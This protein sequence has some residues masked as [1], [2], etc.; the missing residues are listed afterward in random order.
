MKLRSSAFFA[1]VP[2]ALTPFVVAH[3]GSGAAP[4]SPDGGVTG[5]PTGTTPTGD[6]AGSDGG[7]GGSG[8]YNPAGCAFSISELTSRGYTNLALDD[9]TQPSSAS[10]AA[11]I[12]VRVGLHGNTTKGSPGYADPTTSTTFIWETSAQTS[13]ARVRYATSPAGVTSGASVQTGFVYTLPPVSSGLGDT[14]PTYFHEVDLCGLTPGTTYYYQVGGGAPGQ[15]IWSATQS[16]ATVPSSGSI[17]VGV[18][19]DARDAVTTWQAVNQRMTGSGASLLLISGDIVD[20][21]TEESLF[22]QWLSAIWTDDAGP[23]GFLTLGQFIIVPINGNHEN[24]SSEFYANVAIPGSTNTYGNTYASFDVG[25]THFVMVDDQEISEDPSSAE[26]A[27]QLAWIASDLQAANADRT[28]HPFIVTVS[29]RGIYSTSDHAVDSDVLQARTSL[30]PLYSQYNVDLVMNGH[31][32]E[33][34]RSK[35]LTWNASAGVSTPNIVDAGGTTYVINAGA[36]ADP[37]AVG[38]YPASFTNNSTSLVSPSPYIG[39]YVLLTLSGSTLT[40]NAYGMKAS[41]GSVA[42][43]TVIDTLVLQH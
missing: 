34:E 16:F 19:G 10:G 21:G 23:G 17:T 40:L 25:N 28:N 5:S 22:S 13:N 43:D 27:A 35:P 39:C 38:Q 9:T 8:F 36:G 4:A 2:L 26:A 11:P 1:L 7:T 3:C 33:Y 15:E 24:E 29:H 30:A 6:A 12:R 32:H 42:G 41:G 18:F 31:D 20:I 14:N 37:Y